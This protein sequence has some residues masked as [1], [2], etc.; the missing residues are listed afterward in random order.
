MNSTQNEAWF[1]IS[2][3]KEISAAAFLISYL[4]F[5]N[6]FYPPIFYLMSLTMIVSAIMAGPCI[7]RS[8]SG[9]ATREEAGPRR[10]ILL[11]L[12]IL[13][14]ATVGFLTGALGLKNFRSI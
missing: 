3:F 11:N 8:A 7:P 1:E 12:L 2:P 4:L 9:E 5:L 10:L 14:V 6:T 13:A